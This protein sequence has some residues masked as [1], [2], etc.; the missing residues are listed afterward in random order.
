MGSLEQQFND[1]F[2]RYSDELFRHCS[3]RL[4]DR[5]RALELV[6]ECF[7]R[8]WE[9]AQHEGRHIQELRPFLYRTLRHLIID[10]YRRKKAT[11]LEQLAETKEMDAELLLPPAEDNTLEAAINR[12]EGKE[13]LQALQ[14]LPDPYREVLLLRYVDEL[15]P[16]EAAV[17]TGESENVISVR[18][19]RAL[20]KLKDI[21]DQYETH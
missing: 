17:A 14:K 18:T 4:S 7:A 9:Y 6:Q 13:A 20:K 12:F 21:L 19:H 5:E 15:T 3:M 10:E 16:R 1:A 8:S 2:V 11:S